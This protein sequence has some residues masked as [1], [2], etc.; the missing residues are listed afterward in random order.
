MHDGIFFLGG[1][2]VGGGQIR[3]LFEACLS[4]VTI[5]YTGKGVETVEM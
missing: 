1:G 5:D 3:E 2:G 4:L